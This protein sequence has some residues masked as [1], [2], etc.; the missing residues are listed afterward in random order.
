ME[1]QLHTTVSVFWIWQ[2]SSAVAFYVLLHITSMKHLWNDTCRGKLK[3]S[4]RNLLQCHFDYQILALTHDMHWTWCL[5]LSIMSMWYDWGIMWYETYIL[6][7]VLYRWKGPT[8]AAPWLPSPIRSILSM[9]ACALCMSVYVHVELYPFYV[10]CICFRA[11]FVC[12][13]LCFCWL[14][15]LMKNSVYAFSGN[16]NWT[17]SLEALGKNICWHC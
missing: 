3:L 13:C 8:V 11:W 4:D 2:C 15:I 12:Y 16:I 9:H 5:H 10:T 17:S 7:C 6:L 14:K 1:L